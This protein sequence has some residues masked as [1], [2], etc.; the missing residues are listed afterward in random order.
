MQGDCLRHK[1]G[2]ELLCVLTL[3]YSGVHLGDF[4]LRVYDAQCSNPAE[5][6]FPFALRNCITQ[7]YFVLVVL[8]SICIIVR[9]FVKNK[10][11]INENF[12]DNYV[13][14]FL[15]LPNLLFLTHCFN[16]VLP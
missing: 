11:I 1:Y 4:I 5:I 2:Q 16:T 6:I 7:R 13:L 10:L 3:K 14:P 8:Y 12:I 9:A 15:D